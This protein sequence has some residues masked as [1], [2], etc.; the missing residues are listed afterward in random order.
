[1]VSAGKIEGVFGDARLRRKAAAE[2]EHYGLS[3]RQ[4]RRAAHRALRARRELEHWR[5]ALAESDPADVAAVVDSFGEVGE[6]PP[7]G[8]GALLLT[9]HYGLYPLLWL[10]LKSRV[11]RFTLVYSSELYRPDV[12]DDQYRRYAKLG[13]VPAERDDLDLSVLGGRAA[14]E[15]AKERLASGGAVLIFPDAVTV[16]LDRPG[17]LVCRVGVATV[18]YPGGA[19]AL[20]QAPAVRLQGVVLRDSTVVWAT[21]R[22][23]P[24]TAAEVTGV[25]QELL[26]TAVAIDPAPWEAWFSE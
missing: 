15:R 9:L 25:L 19:A 23:T 3:R 20:A 1:M 10:W 18:A 17:A 5:R 6:R 7:P 11:P 24:A 22:H 2:L 13:I 16:P 14:L 8:K 26:D 12:G 4:A 21:P